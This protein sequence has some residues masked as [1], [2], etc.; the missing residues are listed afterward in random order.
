MKG[1]TLD[2]G[3]LIGFDRAKRAVVTRIARAVERKLPIAVPAG[4]LA[5]AWRD[6]RRQARLARLLASPGVTVVSLDDFVARAAGQLC[7]V[8]NTSD[9]I[10]AAVVICARMREHFVLTSDAPD[11]RR[12]DARLQIVP[13]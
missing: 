3:A 6:G 13:I 12:L 9:V 10:D 7:A 8:T 4:A 5:Q 11:L 2:T 1:V